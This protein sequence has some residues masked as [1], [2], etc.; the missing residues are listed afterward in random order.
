MAPVR[1]GFRIARSVLPPVQEAIAAC[2]LVP[3]G[4]FMEI[5]P[6]FAGTRGNDEA[7]PAANRGRQEDGAGMSYPFEVSF[8][9]PMP[10]TI[11]PMQ[12]SRATV[13]GS[14]STSMPSSAVPT[15]PMPT[16]TA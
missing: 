11:R 13:A 15:A 14:F 16:H 3:P 4:R 1:G 10:A 2:R 9:P 6:A 8:R 5:V 7:L 12:T